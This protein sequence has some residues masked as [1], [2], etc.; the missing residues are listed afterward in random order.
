MLVC[1][2]QNSVVLQL[3]IVGLFRRNIAYKGKQLIIPLYKAI[4]RP[5]LGYC[6]Q[7]WRLHRMKDIATLEQI[8]RAATKMI[9]ELRDICYEERLK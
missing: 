3:Q 8:Q 9:P 2:F 6:I 1:K 7:A 5:Q 4:V